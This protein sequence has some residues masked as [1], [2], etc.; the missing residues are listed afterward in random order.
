MSSMTDQARSQPRSGGA[1]SRRAL[2]QRNQRVKHYLSLVTPIAAH[3][4]RR[5]PEPV[6]DLVQVGLLGLLRAAELYAPET[7]T[8]FEAF[9]RPHIRG[10]ILHYLRDSAWAV[11]LPR[12]QMELQDRLRQLKA[13]WCCRHGQEPSAEDLRLALH[14]SH[15][16]WQDLLRGQAMARPWGL[17]GETVEQQMGGLEGAAAGVSD[18]EERDAWL[19]SHDELARQLAALD[20]SLRQV[21]QRVVLSG[22]TYRRTA[23]QLQV[24]PMTVQRRLK[25][26]LAE[27]RQ[28][29]APTADARISSCRNR[30]PVASVVPAC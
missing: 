2:E 5:C 16:Q 15:A 24:S 10:A 4:G 23:A 26:G 21:V 30:R 8:P 7:A 3:Y 14:L 13:Q 17:D 28:A 27:L 29:L 9:A 1:L 20:P 25:R 22:W 11:R 6:D 19:T 18:A 12:R